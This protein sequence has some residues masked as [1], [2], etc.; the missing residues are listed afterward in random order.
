MTPPPHHPQGG[1]IMQRIDWRQVCFRQ[2]AVAACLLVTAAALAEERTAVKCDQPVA[3]RG[4][5]LHPPLA[6]DDLAGVAA[7]L[8]GQLDRRL[9]AR[10]DETLDWIV[11]NT[12]APGVT[13]AVAIPGQ[14]IWTASRGAAVREPRVELSESA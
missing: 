4:P 5:A 14:G 12:P 2:A 6:E 10:F 9:A 1:G 13:A 3:Y 11:A 7:A 8:D